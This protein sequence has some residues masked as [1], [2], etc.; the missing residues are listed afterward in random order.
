MSGVQQIQAVHARNLA[1][2]RSRLASVPEVG[3]FWLIDDKLAA[4][5][6][7]S[8]PPCPSPRGQER[9]LDHISRILAASSPSTMPDSP[10]VYIW[11]RR[12][13]VSDDIR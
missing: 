11:K 9:K 3:I 2:Q 1:V 6:I 13:T 12:S 8:M 5:S 7:P 4:D 10:A